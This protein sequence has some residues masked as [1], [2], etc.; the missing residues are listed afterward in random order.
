MNNSKDNKTGNNENVSSK[1]DLLNG[2]LTNA[3]ESNQ[4]N[5]QTS[6]GLETKICKNC[7]AA[8]PKDT[9]LKY[10]DYCGYEFYHMNQ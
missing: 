8:R 10:C 6:A 4:N 9:N 3:I 7:G 1:K 2:I 5:V